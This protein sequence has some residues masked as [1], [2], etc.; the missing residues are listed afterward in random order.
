MSTPWRKWA[1]KVGERAVDLAVLTVRKTYSRVKKLTRK[2]VALTAPYIQGGHEAYQKHIARHVRP[3]IAK[4]TPHFTR[5]TQ[6]ALFYVLPIFAILQRNKKF[7]GVAVTTFLL[8]VAV[9]AAI[10]VHNVQA[11]KETHAFIFPAHVS[12]EGFENSEAISSQELGTEAFFS[13]FTMAGVSSRISFEVSTSSTINTPRG[14]SSTSSSTTSDAGA[15]STVPE[16]SP[17]VVPVVPTEKATSTDSTSTVSVLLDK[18]FQ[19]KIAL[20]QDTGASTDAP[21]PA[22]ADAPA[23]TADPVP[24]TEPTADTGATVPVDSSSSDAV[25]STSTASLSTSTPVVAV[26]ETQPRDPRFLST[27]AKITLK[28]CHILTLE[29]FGVAAPLSDQVL[30]SASI[31]ISLAH[32]A[33][34]DSGDRIVVRSYESGRWN[35]IGEYAVHGN[36]DN[37]SRGGYFSLPLPVARWQDLT[38]L[39]LTIEYVREDG[40]DARSGEVGDSATYIDAAWIDTAFEAQS[41]IDDLAQASPNVKAALIAKEAEERL[42]KRDHLEIDDKTSVDFTHPVVAE[43]ATLRLAFG[44]SSR[45]VLGRGEEYVSV[46]NI[47]KQPEHVHL[48]FYLPQEGGRIEKLEHFA[49]NIPEEKVTD[50]TA[51]V[52]YFCEKGWAAINE[53]STDTPIVADASSTIA[54]N[55]V[56]KNETHFCSGL[57]DDKTNCYAESVKVGE[58]SETVY[59]RGW[60]EDAA[61]V[62]SFRDDEGVFVKAI[63]SLTAKMPDYLVPGSVKPA[64]YAL[65]IDIEAGA[66]RYFRVRYTSP[67]NSRGDLYVEAAAASGNFGLGSAEFEGSWNW[68]IPVDLA[69]GGSDSTASDTAT[70]TEDIPK[71]ASFALGKL[72]GE[73]WNKVK[74]DGSDIRFTDEDAQYELPFTL[75]D[76]SRDGHAGTITLKL[77]ENGGVLPRVFTYIGDAKA[78]LPRAEMLSMDMGTSTTFDA[79]PMWGA[80]E[81]VIPGEHR[82]FDLDELGRERAHINR[83]LSKTREFEAGENPTFTFQYKPQQAST[84]RAFRKFFGLK[85]FTVENVHIKQA[86]QEYPVKFDVKYNENF[87]WTIILDASDARKII[88]GKATLTFDIN[89]GGKTFSDAYDFEWGLLAINVNKAT[90]ERGETARFSMGALSENGNTV[91]DAKLKLFVT[92]PAS[93]T[94]EVVV[95]PSGKCDGN[96]LI[97]VPDYSAQMNVADTGDYKMKLVRLDDA[98]TVL[99][100]VHDTFHVENRTPFVIERT[101]PTRINP[102]YPYTMTLRVAAREDYNGDFIEHVPGDFTI[103]TAAGAATSTADNGDQILTWHMNMKA[104]EYSQLSYQF[105]APDKS[106]FTFFMGPATIGTGDTVYTEPRKWQI[107]SDA[108]GHMLIFWSKTT[109]PVSPGTTWSCVSCVGGAFYQ[110]YVMGSSTYAVTG[111][112]LTSTHTFTTTVSDAIPSTGVA[113]SNSGS[114]VSYKSHTHSFTPSFTAGSNLPLSKSLSIFSASAAGE[115]QVPAGAIMFFETIPSGWAT[116]TSYEGYFPYGEATSSIAAT[117]GSAA[118]THTVSGTTGVPLS[119]VQYSGTGSS[120]AASNSAHTHTMN[121]T[122]TNSVSNSPPFYSLRMASSTALGTVPNDAITMWDSTPAD[123]WLDY[124]SST[125]STMSSRFVQVSAVSGALGG[126]AAHTHADVNNAPLNASAMSKASSGSNFA[127]GASHTHTA[128]FSGFST[129][130]NLPPYATAIFAKREVGVPSFTQKDFRF[131]VNTNSVDV[132]DPWPVGSAADLGEDVQVTAPDQRIKPGNIFRVRMNMLVTNATATVSNFPLKLQYATTSAACSAATNW[133]DVGNGSS[134]TDVH[135]YDNSLVSDGS[136]LANPTLTIA[137]TTQLE[138][139]NESGVTS[140]FNNQAALGS[141]AEWDWALQA[142]SNISAGS[143]YCLRMAETNGKIFSAYSRYPQFQTNNPPAAPATTAPFDHSLVGVTSPVLSFS[144]TDGEA[145]GLQYDV[146]ISADPTFTSGVTEYTT[147]NNTVFSDVTDPSK[148]TP[149]PSGDA[150]QV[151]PVSGT[152]LDNTTYWWRVRAKDS[153]GSTQ[154]GSWSTFW[155]FTTKIGTTPTAWYQTTDAQFANDDLSN[156]TSTSGAVSRLSSGTMGT[157]TGPEIDFAGGDAGT[158]VWGDL[159]QTRSGAASTTVQYSDEA[160]NWINIPDSVVAGNSLGLTAGTVN[161]RLIDPTAYPALRLVETFHATAAGSLS[162]WE[163][164]WDY[165]TLPPALASPFGNQKVNTQKPSLLFSTTNPQGHAIIYEVEYATSSSFINSTIVRSDSASGFVDTTDGSLSPFPSGHNV[166]YTFPSNLANN[167][168]YYWRTRGKDNT[169]GVYSFYSEVRA[170]VVDTSVSLTTWYQGHQGQWNMDT[171]IGATAASSSV[172]QVATTSDNVLIA[173][174]NGTASAPKYRMYQGGSVSAEASALDVGSS[175][176]W[177]IAKAS[178]V[179]DQYI[180]ATM[181]ANRAINAQVYEGGSWSR[182]QLLT[183]SAASVQRRSF[184]I[185]YEKGGRALATWCNGANAS[186]RLF[187]GSTWGAEQAITLPNPQFKSGSQ[188]EIVHL[189]SNPTTNQIAAIFRNTGS[190]FYALIWDGASGTWGNGSLFS[191]NAAQPE[192]QDDGSAVEYERTSGTALFIAPYNNTTGTNGFVWRYWNGSAWGNTE[193]TYVLSST[194][195]GVTDLKWA[196]L[197]RDPA[198]DN[199]LLCGVSQ[200]ASTD[201]GANTE[202]VRWIGS[203][204]S[205]NATPLRGE[206]YPYTR[207]AQSNDCAYEAGAAGKVVYAADES[208]STPDGSASGL[209]STWDEFNVSTGAFTSG[210]SGTGRRWGAVGTTYDWYAGLT[211][212]SLLAR[213]SLSG[214]ILSLALDGGTTGTTP[215]G[216]KLFKFKAG[217]WQNYNGSSWVSS[218]STAGTVIAASPISTK[219]YGQPFDMAVQE[220]LLQGHVISQAINFADGQSPGWKTAYIASTTPAGTSLLASVEYQDTYGNWNRI[221]DADLPGNSVGTSSGVIDLTTVNVNTYS[222]IRMRADMTCSS[223]SSCPTLN[224]WRVEWKAGVPISGTFMKFDRVASSTIGT[225]KYAVNG[226]YQGTATVSNGVWTVAN[227]NYRNGDTVTVWASSTNPLTQATAVVKFAGSGNLSGIELDENWLTIG[228]STQ[229][230][231]TITNADIAKYDNYDEAGSTA[232]SDVASNVDG[233]GNLTLCASG[234]CPQFSLY[235]AANT[236]WRPNSAAGKTTTTYNVLSPGDIVADANI[237]KVGGSWDVQG[238]FNS[239]TSKVIM[240]ATSGAQSIDMTSASLY[241]FYDLTFGEA[242][243]TAVWTPASAVYVN[244]DINVNFGTYNPSGIP[245]T[246]ERNLAIG[247]SGLWTTGTAGVMFAGPPAATWSDLSSGQNIGQVTIDG[248]PKVI[249][250]ASN[251]VASSTIIGADD[252]LA[253]GVYALT[254][255]GSFTNNHT[256]SGGTGKIIMN[257]GGAA[258]IKQG[259]SA[260]ASLELKSGSVTWVDAVAS[261]TGD[262]IVSGGNH[263]F[264]SELIVGGSFS[265]TSGTFAAA[266]TTTFNSTAS[267]KT[268]SVINNF[269][270]LLFAG[271]GSWTFNSSATTTSN[272]TVNSGS[273]TLPSTQLNVAGSFTNTSAVSGNG[274][275]LN[276]TGATARLTAG[277]GTL[278]SILVSSGATTLMTA[279]TSLSNN[280]TVNSGAT[281]NLQSGG[282]FNVAGNFTNN[283]T[284]NT[285]LTEIVMNGGGALQFSAGSATLTKL[286]FAGTGSFT[287]K[288]NATTTGDFTLA[289]AVNGFTYESGKQLNVGGFFANNMASSATWTGSTL[290]LYNGGT[291]AINT[292]TASAQS[293]NNLTLDN[294]TQL[295]MWNS[296]VSGTVTTNGTSSLYAMNWGNAS[297]ALRIYGTYVQATGTAYWDYSTDFDGATSSRQAI[298]TLAPNAAVNISPNATLDA[299]GTSTAS[300]TVNSLS[301]VWKMSMSSSTWNSSFATWSNMSAL[302]ISIGTST[303]IAKLDNSLFTAA[304]FFGATMLKLDSSVIA[305]NNGKQFINVGFAST[306]GIQ[307]SVTTA[308]STGNYIRFKN[309]FGSL[310]GEANDADF[311]GDPGEVR[312]D[313]SQIPITLRGKVYLDAG[314]TIMP[315]AVCGTGMQDIAI[316]ILPG[317]VS[318]TTSCAADGSYS[319][320]VTVKGDTTIIIYLKGVA[321][322]AVTVTRSASSPTVNGLDLYASRINVRHEDVTP[323]TNAALTGFDSTNDAD[324]KYTLSGGNITIPNTMELRV[325]PNMTYSPGGNVTLSPGGAFGSVYLGSTST[326]AFSGSQSMSIGGDFIGA[327]GSTFTSASSTVN[328]TNTAMHTLN[329][330]STLTFWNLSHS[331]SASTTIT[332]NIQTMNT[333]SLAGGYLTGAGNIDHYGA[334]FGSGAGYVNFTGGTVTMYGTSTLGGTN[335]QQWTFNNL[336]VSSGATVTKTG[337]GVTSASGQLNI[338]GTGY[339]AFGATP[340]EFTGAGNPLPGTLNID[341][342]ASSTLRLMPG[343][344]KVLTLPSLTVGNIIVGGT[345]TTTL[346]SGVTTVQG[347][348]S[349]SG[350]SCALDHNNGTVLFAGSGSKTINVGCTSKY[351]DT[352]TVDDTTGSWTVTNH[353]IANNLYLNHASAFTINAGI[354]FHVA[355]DMKNHIGDKTVWS[356]TS[357]LFTDF[358]G[359]VVVNDRTDP[360]DQYG[361]IRLTS[362]SSGVFWNSSS[363]VFTQNGGGAAFYNAGAISGRLDIIGNY[364]RNGGEE[365]WSYARDFDGTVLG[366]GQQRAANVNFASGASAVYGGTS[367]LNVIGGANATTSVGSMSGTYSL[368]ASGTAATLSLADFSGMNASGLQ[369]RGQVAVGAIDDVY[370]HTSLAAGTL[371]TVDGSVIDANPVKILMRDGFATSTAGTMKNVSTVGASVSVWRFKDHY[372]NIAGEAY[373]ADPG[374]NNNPGYIAW[375]DSSTQV[376]ISGKLLNGAGTAKSSL[377]TGA[378]MLGL[379]V[380]GSSTVIM[381]SCSA[382]DGSFSFPNIL[383]LQGG[384]LTVFTTGTATMTNAYIL[385]PQTNVTNLYL[386]D[387]TISLRNENASPISDNNIAMYSYHATT[388]NILADESS[389]SLVVRNNGNLRIWDGK[390]YAP[391]GPVTIPGSLYLG[392]NS[393]ITGT[394]PLTLS[395]AGAQVVYASSSVQIPGLL[396]TNVTG[397]YVMTNIATSTGN[398]SI[399]AGSVTLPT[400]GIAIGGSLVNTAT[401]NVSATTT[402]F[403]SGTSTITTSG[404]ALAGLVFN[405]AGAFTMSD[406]ATSTNLYIKNGAVTL[407]GSLNISGDFVNTGGSFTAG[408]G[409]TTL[410]GVGA[411]T[412]NPGGSSFNHLKIASGNYTTT[413]AN[414]TASGDVSIAGGA[415]LL[416]PA[417]NF[418]IGGS[419]VNLGS[420]A[421]N[422]TSSVEFT[423]TTVGKVIQTGSSTLGSMTV[424]GPGG[425]WIAQ[426]ATTTGA[427]IITSPGYVQA[428]SSTLVSQGTFTNTGGGYW[429]N[430]TLRL[431]TTSITTLGP[432]NAASVTYGTVLIDP[433]V[434]VSSWNA[435]YATVTPSAGSS[436]YAMN[437]GGL[438][439]LKIFGTYT[440][441]SG[442]DYWSYGNDFDGASVSRKV[443]VVFAS[444]ASATYSTGAKLEVVGDSSGGNSTAATSSSGTYTLKVQDGSF[445]SQYASF[446]GMDASGV[447]LIGTTTL[448]LIDN[449]SFAANGG[450][451]VTISGTTIDTNP[452]MIMNTDSFTGATTNVTV[453]GSPQGYVYF[454][455]TTGALA[456]ETFDSDGDATGCGSVRWD[457]STCKITDEYAFRWRNDDGGEAAPDSMWYDASWSSR[458]RVNVYNNT[459]SAVS[460][461]AVKVVVPFTAGMRTD[462]ADL[463][464]TNSSGTTSIP[465]WIEKYNSSQAIVWVKADLPASAS[466]DVYV[467]YGNAS[468]SASTMSGTNT[469]SY[470]EDFSSY[471]GS[472]SGETA[473]KFQ[474]LSAPLDTYTRS[475][476]KIL[477]G[478]GTQQLQTSGGGIARFDK[479]L[480]RG[481]RMRTVFNVDST[482]NDAFCTTFGAQSPAS[483]AQNYAVCIN[484]ASAPDT[485][486][487]RKNAKFD[488]SSDGSVQLDNVSLG[489]GLSGWYEMTADWKSNGDITAKVGDMNGSVVGATGVPNDSTYTSGGFG[490]T[491][492]YLKSGWTFVSAYPYIATDPTVKVFGSQGHAGASFASSESTLITGVQQNTNLRLRL[493]IRNTDVARTGLKFRLDYASKGQFANCGQVPQANYAP[494]PVAS[495]CGASPL[496]MTT[497]SNVTNTAPTTPLLSMPKGLTFTSGSIVTDPTNTTGSYDMAGTSYSEFEYALHVTNNVAGAGYCMRASNN[498]SPLDSYGKTAEMGLFNVPKFSNWN[499]NNGNNIILTPGGTAVVTATGTVTDYNGY[500]DLNQSSIAAEFHHSEVGACTNGANDPNNC[501]AP[502]STTCSIA[503]CNG[504]S[505]DVS[506]STNMYYFADPT[507]THLGDAWLSNVSIATNGG[508]FGSSTASGTLLSFKAIGL[509]TSTLDYG[510]VAVGASTG[511]FNATTSVI[512]LGNT[513][514]SPVVVGT[515]LTAAGSAIASSSEYVASSTFNVDACTLCVPVASAS[516]LGAYVTKQTS[517]GSLM[518]KLLYFG[519]KVPFGTKALDHSGTVTITAQ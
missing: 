361:N 42:K 463:R 338:M 497:S 441:T 232:H 337:T 77:P 117:Q 28:E 409:T 110:R 414:M 54:Y 487:I 74:E 322:N 420:F 286:T 340:L 342:L 266:A 216:L 38:D 359:N 220:G 353:I 517:L 44:T 447:Q 122:T 64:A 297:G 213:A 328:F 283:G 199:L 212:T 176:A 123:G 48:N 477:T 197:R 160:G 162:D 440:K 99:A 129:D 143:V 113:G 49:Y 519:L 394:N 144:A 150:I 402:F 435:D 344:G 316:R 431:A 167:T 147:P 513:T 128:T 268:I 375:D 82:K 159:I 115:V 324:V 90:L 51:P 311:N 471:P 158:T 457:D 335:G 205:I 319:K 323:M 505:C 485:L 260:L 15:T 516:P 6:A 503:Q 341:F 242:A 291:L 89:E 119:G 131:Y 3:H 189:A 448:P 278:G 230:G 351:F 490:H 124:S 149:Y 70:T 483:N 307:S 460:G 161:L 138:G 109:T 236:T 228:A 299:V 120:G 310:A 500:A 347:N 178:P 164:T 18:I 346:S 224:N 98:G 355:N 413:V 19:P 425:G 121:A 83:F 170:F 247:S 181:G 306:T 434:K 225:V 229:S 245:T 383:P 422:A 438:G 397:N 79:D 39:M 174:A 280:L 374:A 433:N 207:H 184:D 332:S 186:Y 241:K 481:I 326:L 10:M 114:A 515:D 418:K 146:Q 65:P 85:P 179:N 336:A 303:N 61:F 492:W 382:V 227:A 93:S 305:A 66:T 226:T 275:V 81:F 218:P 450:T 386:Y 30:R 279:T 290:R 78:E 444:G 88:P 363:T 479:T 381:A 410:S 127:A 243:S 294:N 75:S 293:Y 67:F 237:L 464:F 214:D 7:L 391:A 371:V 166:K 277:G 250:L 251:V 137:P 427:I 424:D 193:Q 287:M 455:G 466:T 163:V 29:G 34:R 510:S 191:T 350:G 204:N 209:T 484:G 406:N 475:T 125:G 86:G 208:W 155:A 16:T 453:S 72:P 399:N 68:R 21:A 234:G 195:G 37:A 270:N 40:S 437:A 327:N 47:G 421:A 32:R 134:N 97:D 480:S 196:R 145:D 169:N 276:M 428:T 182:L 343:A 12:G 142:G 168:T 295:R 11:E 157:I 358:P 102:K 282:Q 292:K 468:A 222:T 95:T 467:Y 107:A 315:G 429:G 126:S 331:G 473:T 267:G 58:E 518:S 366:V 396:F 133:A 249:T 244:D 321:F 156:A 60:Q 330:S 13:D 56:D 27:C 100:E 439:S 470:F 5:I 26:V 238:S 370:F 33:P 408:T 506:C 24:A 31:N 304:P 139:Y 180:L 486:S 502:A 165:K 253:L 2:S 495:S 339:F 91:C 364:T 22:P 206:F 171:L 96:N 192:P 14:D 273:V 148:K 240:N 217:G 507:D 274:G 404:R 1:E 76:F 296:S 318:T 175:V 478:A 53:V 459:A 452:S 57:N 215:Q 496:C 432:K 9:S 367:T 135:G 301:G 92:D 494:V 499:L 389:G 462:Y 354:D 369:L 188:C 190:S 111:G 43:G 45:A 329:A 219:P 430:S 458:M 314:Q 472:F 504:F 443:N 320:G 36:S 71:Y 491:Y 284:L 333:V 489:A 403:G 59:K 400:T 259:A 298:V 101:G 493:G 376:T 380:Q 187:D 210:V 407:P 415:T 387:N 465:Y 105:D 106:P 474:A 202:F 281:L 4:V 52:A 317:A 136:N 223:Y 17:V 451:A 233:S 256:L 509:S 411:R 412:L 198:S 151:T 172:V 488:G 308:S 334:S 416:F 392:V 288:G 194:G 112:A 445:K 313:D 235:V 352:M 261:T 239:G 349:T 8:A 41:N 87:A 461:A 177:A 345:G 271:S 108:A 50:K 254:T 373:D 201:D 454:T 302:G 398:I 248:T 264:P 309:H 456:G 300:T 84:I 140:G 258:T 357:N 183:T 221:P 231:Q 20:A 378:T 263:T 446:A 393:S 419:L 449:T 289:G 173:Y 153:G 62:G 154:W 442:T 348:Y 211:W 360:G 130:N 388:T 269:T 498:G 185:A 272:F 118:H 426:S 35:Y 469:F 262:V 116:T 23:P 312:W 365:D 152:L 200:Y 482:Q 46:T 514:F 417:G 55:C 362:G 104:G 103:L 132:T 423:A 94:Q 257:P 203:S 265:Q 372:G 73:F 508:T 476:A 69:I 377:C 255:T 141:V 511:A 25:V 385:D 285:N 368:I 80:P 384:I 390:T 512:N 356:P 436:L 325:M 401:M 252:T 501:Y 405:G 395:G 63:D 379:N 246:V